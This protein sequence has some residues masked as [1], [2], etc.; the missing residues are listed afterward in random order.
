MGHKVCPIGLRIG[1]TE[2]WRSRWYCDKKNFGK[3]LVEDQKIRK[4]IKANYHYAGISKIEIERT[5]E[6][7][8]VIL[9]T[10]R[11]GIIIGRKGNEADR[12]QSE[13]EGLIGRAVRLEIREVEK[14]EIDAQ[15]VAEGVAE[16][17]E[18]RQSFRRTMKRTAETTMGMGALGVKILVSGRLGGA[19]MSRTE[20]CI[21][22]SIPLQTLRGLIDYGFT[23]ARTQYGQIGVKVWIYKGK[24]EEGMTAFD[25]KRLAAAEAASAPGAAPTP[26]PEGT[27]PQ[28]AAPA[29]QK[30]KETVNNAVDAKKSEVP[31]GPARPSQR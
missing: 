29:S 10:A 11:P 12:L 17:L 15:L 31:Q 13:L 22:G 26:S 25:L 24:I 9:F 2:D 18:R 14:P 6:E 19:E 1:I 3:L 23:E 5:R 7:V 20:K 8:V 4:H 27:A 16:Q 28:P 30:T 21:M